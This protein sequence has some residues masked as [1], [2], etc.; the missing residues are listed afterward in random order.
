MLVLVL[1]LE[2]GNVDSHKTMSHATSVTQLGG[3]RARLL[4]VRDV[5]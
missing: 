1:V 2:P 3:H 4:S 5:V